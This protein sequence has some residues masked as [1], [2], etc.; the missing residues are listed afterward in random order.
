MTSRPWL[1]PSL[2]LL[3]LIAACASSPPAQLYVIGDPVEPVQAVVVQSGRPVVRLL[4]V[5]VPDY[6]DTREILR[7]HG[8]NELTASPTGLWAERLSVGVT[9]ALATSLATRLPDVVVLTDEP[10]VPPSRQIMVDVL[11]FDIGTD[12][13]CLL[14]AQ[15]AIVSS[16]GSKV[17]DRESDSFVEQAPQS[18]DANLV[19]AMTRAIN[20]LA[21]QIVA[22]SRNLE[23]ANA[24]GDNTPAQVVGRHAL[25]ANR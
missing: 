12:G 21:L 4:P 20:R 11:A 10:R 25:H 1:F 6:L 16:D 15:W 5:S 13:R 18:T 9:H 8:R 19:A 17:L 3:L 7:R 14:T 22:A 2:A 24:G 23:R